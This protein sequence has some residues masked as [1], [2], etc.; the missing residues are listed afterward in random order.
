MRR[1]SRIGQER[2][3][4]RIGRAVTLG[5][6]TASLGAVAFVIWSTAAKAQAALGAPGE[7]AFS[8]FIED[9][10][11]MPGLSENDDG[12][13]FDLFHGGRLA[14][15]R[16]VGEAEPSVVRG[17][18]SATLAQL[19]WRASEIEP[20]VYRRGQARLIFLVE[21]RRKR[22]GQRA[23]KGLEVVFVIT[24]EARAPTTGRRT[25]ERS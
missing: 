12:Y 1:R 10:P 15:A 20:Y 17:F 21:P 23:Q 19:G 25:D 9:L 3:Q 22:P 6:V 8:G 18:Y 5:L 4:A 13:A 7:T 14:E 16:L 24:P 2:R 11:I